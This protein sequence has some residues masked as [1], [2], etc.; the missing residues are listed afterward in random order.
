MQGHY[1]LKR[2]YESVCERPHA[3]IKCLDKGVKGYVV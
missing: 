2:K 3:V 1:L